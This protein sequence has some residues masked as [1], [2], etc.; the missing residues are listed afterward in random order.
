MTKLNMIHQTTQTNNLQLLYN[1]KYLRCGVK[2]SSALFGLLE[3]GTGGG[4]APLPLPTRLGSSGGAKA[5][6]RLTVGDREDGELPHLG[7]GG[8]ND[9]RSPGTLSTTKNDAM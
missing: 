8:G 9:G 1:I 2:P 4:C 6:D 3:V 5:G 7:G